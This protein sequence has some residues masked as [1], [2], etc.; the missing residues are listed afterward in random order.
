MELLAQYLQRKHGGLRIWR[1]HLVHHRQQWDNRYLSYISW[2]FNVVHLPVSI[3]PFQVVITMPAK[4][5]DESIMIFHL[6]I[7]IFHL[8]IA[9]F[10]I[11]GEVR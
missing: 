11:S 1:E 6:E 5:H 10:H 8:S 2:G 3:A 7:V 9:T 4:H